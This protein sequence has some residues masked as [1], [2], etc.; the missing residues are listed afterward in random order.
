M[1]FDD[2]NKAKT[3]LSRLNA[4]EEFNAVAADMLNWTEDDT[5]LGA[6][7]KSA[8]DPALA[9]IAISSDAGSPAGPVETAF[10]QHVIVVDKITMG[11]QAVLA[12]VKEKIKATLRT[13]KSIDLLYDRANEFEDAI[14]HFLTRNHRA[15]ETAS[16]ALE[17]AGALIL[18]F[19]SHLIVAWSSNGTNFEHFHDH[20][21]TS[22]LVMA[23][24]TARSQYAAKA[25][26]MSRAAE[27]SGIFIELM[28]LELSYPQ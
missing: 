18:S 23:I 11:G 6:V 25:K 5:K 16:F 24:A 13:E 9:E 4:G 28:E 26:T 7:N 1:V 15:S 27:L 14:G 8:L 19:L 2:T 3:A 12:D 20:F 21:I 17:C 22:S 10:G